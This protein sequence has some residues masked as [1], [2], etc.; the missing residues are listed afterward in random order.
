[1][2][3]TKTTPAKYYV[4]LKYKCKP[5]EY[6]VIW[7][8]KSEGDTILNLWNECS[9]EAEMHKGLFLESISPATEHDYMMHKLLSG[10]HNSLLD[11]DKLDSKKFN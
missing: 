10:L 2:K 3:N 9:T 4:R 8:S 1:M 6:M 5:A 7:S 11:T